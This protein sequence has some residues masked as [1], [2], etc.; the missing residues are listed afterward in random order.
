MNYVLT[1][2]PTLNTSDCLVIGLFDDNNLPQ[3]ALA[4]DDKYH[5]LITRLTSKLK[6]TGDTAWQADV[7]GHGLLLIHCGNLATFTA[8]YLAKRIDDISS[9]LFKERI[10]SATLCMP[11]LSQHTPDWQIQQMLLRIEDK[12][13]QLLD[14]KTKNQKPKKNE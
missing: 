2:T 8:D 11:Q 6:T 7:D 9:H 1:A 14:F 3:I 5:D 10:I 12:R 13:Y 4:I